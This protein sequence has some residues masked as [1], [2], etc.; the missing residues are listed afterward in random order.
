MNALPPI[1]ILVA[2]DHH[3]IRQGIGAII[4]QAPDMQVAAE[5]DNGEAAL[6]M[7]LRHRPDVTLVDLQMPMMGGLDAIAAIRTHV[8][9][10]RIVVLTTYRGDAQ[11]Q[12][13][14]KAGAS[15]YLLKNMLCAEILDTI[16]AVHAGGRHWPDEVLGKGCHPPDEALSPRETDVIRLVASGNSNKRVA[17]QLGLSEETVKGY[18]SSILSKLGANDRTHAV[19]IAIKRGIIDT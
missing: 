15:G 11:V 8:P 17:G 12:R 10:A 13:A 16:R 9:S 2:D 4:A 3:L 14:L 6:Q 5:A 1:R 19:T 18:V 7:Y